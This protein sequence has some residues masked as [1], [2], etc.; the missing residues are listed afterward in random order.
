MNILFFAAAYCL[1]SVGFALALGRMIA[2]HPPPMRCNVC[3]DVLC[4]DILTGAD[5]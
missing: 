1:A 5:R 2:H 3:D 4:P